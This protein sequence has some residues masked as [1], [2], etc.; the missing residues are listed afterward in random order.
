[1][2]LLAAGQSG[3]A[4]LGCWWARP[5]VRTAALFLYYLGIIVALLIL[6]GRGDFKTAP[7]VYQ[8]F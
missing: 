1:M 2:N 3:R 4:A 8:S 5:A 7:F 6:Y